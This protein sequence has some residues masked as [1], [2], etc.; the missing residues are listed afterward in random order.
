MNYAPRLSLSYDDLSGVVAAFAKVCDELIVYE[1]EADEKVKK[2]HIHLLIIRSQVKDEALRRLAQKTRSDIRM[3][4]NEFWKW[5]VKEEH[6]SSLCSDPYSFI[7]YMSK[8]KLAPKYVKNISGSKVEEYRSK[9]V[10]HTGTP[11][12]QKYDEYEALKSDLMKESHYW[13]MTL[14]RIRTWTMSWYWKRD[15]RLP[16]AG[17]YKRNAASLYL[18]A[19][20]YHSGEPLAQHFEELKNLWY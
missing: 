15:G 7:T 1:H 12:Q 18:F 10:E 5:A 19:S 20:S 3:S 4:G 17:C 11:P 2:T 14:D 16:N 13:T 8:G 9:W 6:K